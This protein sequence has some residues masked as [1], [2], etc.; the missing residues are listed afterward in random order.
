MSYP[1]LHY[2]ESAELVNP[3]PHCYESVRKKNPNY[4]H[5]HSILQSHQLN[6]HRHTLIQ[7]ANDSCLFSELNYSCCYLQ[8]LST[9]SLYS[10][11]YQSETLLFRLHHVH[12]TYYFLPNLQIQ[13]H[14]IPHANR[15][16]SNLKAL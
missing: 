5:S 16:A 9:Q 12:Q 2:Y 7:T 8:C 11:S 3:H 10:S 14:H 1:Y 13:A 4:H 6:F 15:L